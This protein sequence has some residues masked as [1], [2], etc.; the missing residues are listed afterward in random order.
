MG[1]EMCIRDSPSYEWR[2]YGLVETEMSCLTDPTS[3][4]R[5]LVLWSTIVICL[6]D[7]DNATMRFFWM[8]RFMR[9]LEYDPRRM[10]LYR[11]LQPTI[12]LS[13]EEYECIVGGKYL[14]IYIFRCLG[15]KYLDICQIFTSSSSILTIPTSQIEPKNRFLLSPCQN[16][17]H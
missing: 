9:T 3:A 17:R 6:V 12:R 2:T 11:N 16:L 4:V 10:I 8:Q 1:S 15:F 7:D 13:Y 5:N 14:K